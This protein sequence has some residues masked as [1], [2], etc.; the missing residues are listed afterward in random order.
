MQTQAPCSTVNRTDAHR[1]NPP[2]FCNAFMDADQCELHYTP[3]GLCSWNG[4]SCVTDAKCANRIYS[5]TG[6]SYMFFKFHKVGSST[7]GGTLRLALIASTSNVFTSCL[8]FSKLQNK[9][10]AER[11]RYLHCSLCS[12]HDNSLPLLPFFRQ[13]SVLNAPPERRLAA[14]FS[15][16]GAGAVLD[17]HCPQRASIGNRLR[18]GTVF[19][20]PVDR[21]IS[22]YYFLR[23]YCQEKAQRLGRASCVALELDILSWLVNTYFYLHALC[24]RPLATN[25]GLYML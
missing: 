14:L 12:K 3:R 20:R 7:V 22:K 17:K 10:E 11:A 6:Q 4:A 16:P 9:T 1:L 15:V 2:R 5:P 13:L 8:R 25:V 23:T 18:T 21:V 24:M 19:R